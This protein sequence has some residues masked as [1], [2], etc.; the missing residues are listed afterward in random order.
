MS[1][2][3]SSIGCILYHR[4]II[5]SPWTQSQDIYGVHPRHLHHK[6]WRE[7]RSHIL[8]LCWSAGVS[9]IRIHLIVFADLLEL[10]GSLTRGTALGERDAHCSS[11]GQKR[12]S[13]MIKTLSRAEWIERLGSL[14]SWLVAG[15]DVVGMSV[16]M[17][18]SPS[19]RVLSP[20]S[21]PR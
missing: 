13:S 4:L 15:Q 8:I 1:L 12:M 21:G 9:R 17:Q 2:W 18:T 16:R 19:N 3:C 14:L 11:K 5:R 10:S 6:Y 7:P 20:T